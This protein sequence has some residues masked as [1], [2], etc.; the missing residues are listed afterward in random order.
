MIYLSKGVVLGKPTGSCVSVSHCGALHK[1]SGTHARL[2]LAGQHSPCY[3][4][5]P[6]QDDALGQLVVLGIAECDDSLD[7]MALFRLLANCAICPTRVKAPPSILNLTER[8]L[9]KWVRYAGLRLTMAELTMLTDLGIPPA[10][11]LLGEEN[12]QAL[13][14]AIYSIDSIHDGILETMMER[15]PARICAVQ[16]VLGLLRKKKIFL[17]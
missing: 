16:A 3:T 1:L 5:T 4:Q 12:R 6:E 15:S 14:E 11:E 8:R 9:W 10:P 17:I 7:G 2:W 13:T